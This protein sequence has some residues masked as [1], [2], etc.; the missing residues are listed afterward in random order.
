MQPS[1]CSVAP[2]GADMQ[3]RKCSVAYLCQMTIAKRVGVFVPNDTLK[4]KGSNYI[5]SKTC[6]Q[7]Q[8]KHSHKALLHRCAY[9]LYF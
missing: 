1:Q 2:T 7:W 6:F 5:F 3:Q 4:N 9:R 8:D